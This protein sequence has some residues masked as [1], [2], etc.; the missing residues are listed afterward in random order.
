MRT[1][2][3]SS[4]MFRGRYYIYYGRLSWG[5]DDFLA[6]LLA[7]Q[8]WSR[9]T[10][11]IVDAVVPTLLY[12]HDTIIIAAAMARLRVYAGFSAL[13]FAAVR[14]LEYRGRLCRR[15]R[16]TTGVLFRQ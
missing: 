3:S 2:R 10:F 4:S 1:V 7:N 8:C 12:H 5:S 14:V 11:G 9:G 13:L 16:R 6:P 15:S